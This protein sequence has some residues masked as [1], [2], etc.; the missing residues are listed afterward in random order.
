MIK[1]NS[2]DDRLFRTAGVYWSYHATLVDMANDLEGL[3]AEIWAGEEIPDSVRITALQGA[4]AAAGD[5]VG[6]HAEA[7][8]KLL[9]ERESRLGIVGPEG[10]DAS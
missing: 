6:S 4:I 1:I 9:Q 7:L 5:Y 10:E 2:G 3:I 8:N